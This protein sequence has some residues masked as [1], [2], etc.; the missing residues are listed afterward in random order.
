[1]QSPK[2]YSYYTTAEIRIITINKDSKKD[3]T[4]YLGPGFIIKIYPNTNV[5]GN[6][7]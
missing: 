4:P 7:L 2:R 1:M 3:L 6:M 5:I